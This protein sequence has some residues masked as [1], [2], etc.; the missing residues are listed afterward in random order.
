MNSFNN[1]SLDVLAV[2][3]GFIAAELYPVQVTIGGSTINLVNRCIDEDTDY[4]CGGS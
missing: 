1:R 2:L 3:P 4:G